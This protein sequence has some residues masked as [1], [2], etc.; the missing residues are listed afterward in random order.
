MKRVVPYTITETKFAN[1]IYNKNTLSTVTYFQL[2]SGDG[3]GVQKISKINNLF[4]L[5]SSWAKSLG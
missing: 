5:L 3:E 4:I 2:F 1:K